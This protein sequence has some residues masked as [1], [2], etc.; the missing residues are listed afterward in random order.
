MCGITSMKVR[1][2][3]GVCK[4]KVIQFLI[5]PDVTDCIGQ[6]NRLPEI[7]PNSQ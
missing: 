7:L 5:K 3:F 1:F 4:E 6:R 2:F